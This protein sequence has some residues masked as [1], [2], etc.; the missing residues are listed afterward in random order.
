MAVAFY[1]IISSNSTSP[2]PV[3][4][5]G[6]IFF[7]ISNIFLAAGEVFLIRDAVAEPLL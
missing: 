5:A 6:A 2:V 3:R 1:S 7:F 4:D